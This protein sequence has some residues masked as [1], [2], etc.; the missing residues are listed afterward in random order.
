MDVMETAPSPG[1]A[2]SVIDTLAG[3]FF[4]LLRL[5]GVSP[6][7]K[8]AYSLL[9]GDEMKERETET[10]EMRGNS[11]GS[12]RSSRRT[13]IGSW[14]R[15]CLFESLKDGCFMTLEIIEVKYLSAA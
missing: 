12:K 13:K 3:T 2:Q 4:S 10:A 8:L 14:E 9:G 5:Y 1:R 11:H 15:C 6:H 7:W